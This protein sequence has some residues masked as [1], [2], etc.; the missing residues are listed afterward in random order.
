MQSPR[1]ES[2]QQRVQ[3]AYGRNTF[4]VSQGQKKEAG[5]AVASLVGREGCVLRYEHRGRQVYVKEGLVGLVQQLVCCCKWNRK[6]SRDFKWAA[7]AA[8]YSQR[9]TL[10]L[11]SKCESKGGC[12]GARESLL[13]GSGARTVAV[14]EDM[15]ER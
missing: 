1:G 9:T 3:R 8:F 14:Q 4:Q 10:L 7:S 13:G 5:V 2:S 11:S 6:V 12:L 15:G